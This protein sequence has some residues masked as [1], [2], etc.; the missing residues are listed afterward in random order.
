[1]KAYHGPDTEMLLALPYITVPPNGLHAALREVEAEQSR[2]QML[3]VG[4]A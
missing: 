2:V 4:L 3:I 1:M